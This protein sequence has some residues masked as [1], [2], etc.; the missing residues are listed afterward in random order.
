MPVHKGAG[1]I[2]LPGPD[3]KGI[4]GRES[5]TI[6]GVEEMKELSHELRSAL[7]GMRLVPIGGEDKKVSAN[8]IVM[9]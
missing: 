5:E 9:P 1:G 3:V 2:V 4:E 6:G 7:P 8:P